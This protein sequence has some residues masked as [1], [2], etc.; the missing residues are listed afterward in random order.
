VGEKGLRLLDPEAR[1]FLLGPGSKP[2]DFPGLR[3]CRTIEESKSIN[4]YKGPCIILAGSGMCNAGR[5]K[6]H[7]VHNIGRPECTVLFVGYQ[8]PGTLGRQI[9]DGQERVRIHGQTL[10]VRARIEQIHGFSGHAGRSGLLRWLDAFG[11]P[12]RRLFLI[13]GEEAGALHLA[14]ELREKGWTVEVPEY[15]DSFSLA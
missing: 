6:H 4:A 7:L 10:D 8:A 15:L 9:L 3:F 11:K 2:F 1:E 13:H 5:I 14:E 12:P